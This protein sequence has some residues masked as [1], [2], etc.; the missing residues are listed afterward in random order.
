MFYGVDLE[1]SWILGWHFDFG[2]AQLVFDLEV[3]LW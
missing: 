2:Q 1:D 3:S